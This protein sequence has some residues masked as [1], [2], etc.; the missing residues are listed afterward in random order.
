MSQL[1]QNIIR[2]IWEFSVP[3]FEPEDN[4]EYEMEAI[5]DSTI[6]AKKIDRY[7]QKLYYL[8]V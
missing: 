4:K 7:L 2:K 5:R 3:K 6:Y 8:V 1:E